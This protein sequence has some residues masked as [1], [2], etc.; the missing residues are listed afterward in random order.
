MPP[1]GPPPM[2]RDE[3]FRRGIDPDELRNLDVQNAVLQ[4]MIVGLDG[5]DVVRP[6]RTLWDRRGFARALKGIDSFG[7]VEDS[8]VPIRT[9]SVPV[10]DHGKVT[11]VIQLAAPLQNVQQELGQL[12]NTLYVVLP[13]AV[14]L[15][16]FAGVYLT[17]RALRPVARIASAAEQI[18]ATSLSGRLPVHGQDEFAQLS[19]TFNKMLD[20]IELAFSQKEKAY[21]SQVQFTS[22]ASHEL[23]TPLTA[24]RAR[25]GMALR[26]E[27]PAERYRDHIQAIDRASKVMTS[28]LGDLL[29]LASAD[30]GSLKL[31]PGKVCVEALVTDA[32]ASVDTG[33]HSVTAELPKDLV[34]LADRNAITRVLIN[35]IENAVR[36]TPAESPISVGAYQDQNWLV[37]TISDKGPGID[38]AHLPFIFDRFYRVEESR[39]RVSGGSGLGLSIAKAI[40]NGHGGTISMSS[41]LGTG[42][43]VTIRLPLK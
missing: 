38:P 9:L 17:R 20:R 10:R 25:A 14:L 15:M 26:T 41:I 2:D 42:T 22:D 31:E 40:V 19:S 37:M 1:P 11:V 27:L 8:D 30:D 29:T 16:L 36:Y 39:D 5:I 23:R 13:L 34:V 21:Q 4:P 6:D 24:I 28:V 35:L 12:A 3:A 32:M 33:A 18:E 43:A 7:T